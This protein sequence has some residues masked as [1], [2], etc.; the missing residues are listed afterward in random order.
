MELLIKQVRI[1]DSSQ[2]FFGDV[3]IKD[4]IIEELGQ[5]LT[6]D[7]EILNGKSKVL[8][9]SFIDLHC[10][11]RE[12]GFTHKEDLET[13]SK[14]AVKGGYTVVNLMGNTKPV[15]SNMDV[16]NYVNNKAKA[17]GLIEVNQVATITDGLKGDNIEHLKNIDSSVK[18][19]SDDGLGVNNS[20][21]MMEAMFYAKKQN[22]TVM[23][24]AES[25]EFSNVD[26]R[27]AE[28][29]MT[30][31]DVHLCEYTGCSLHMAHVST[32]EAMQYI[33]EG[34][35]KG[36]KLTCEV[37]PHHLALTEEESQ[38]R[39]NPPIRKRDDVEFLIKAIQDGYVDAIAT[40]HAPHTEEDKKN[41]APGI[42]GIETSFSVSYT[43]LVKDGHIS[44]NK[45]SQ[46]MSE[47]P[48]K[49][50]GLNKG[51]LKI[52]YYADMVLVDLEK[53]FIVDSS[54]FESKG[55]NTPFQGKLVFGEILRTFKEGKEVY[56]K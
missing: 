26:M 37:M 23:S 17:I 27:L 39:V 52:G 30:W 56:C 6:K 13:G 44:L 51:Q 41:G 49:I 43:K 8:M 7:C 47:K 11:F 3:Y 35:K 55:K 22:L 34:K 31:R 53:E 4:G 40:D 18:F 54:K 21:V 16:I 48:A 38:Y 14:A 28:N 29:M 2:D 32:K 9:P 12:P 24:H 45:L 15:A 19:I 1:V 25:K 33:I 42:S 20:R 36:L 10:H 46:L 5:N 50:M